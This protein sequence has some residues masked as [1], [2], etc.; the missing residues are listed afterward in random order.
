MTQLRGEP[1][2]LGLAGALAKK[3]VE[4]SHAHAGE[5]ALPAH[6]AV[7]LAQENEQLV[8]DA[9]VGREA[10]V[11]AF[12]GK[13]A[14]RDAV[15]EHA[16]FAQAGAGGDQRAIADLAR[17]GLR[18]ERE[19]FVR[20]QRI[21]AIGIGLE[22]VEQADLLEIQFGLQRG[23]I[24]DPGQVGHLHH[25]VL[26]RSGHAEAGMPDV[27]EIVAEKVADDFR[28]RGVVLARVGRGFF[29]DEPVVVFVGV[30]CQVGFGAADIACEKSA[31]GLKGKSGHVRVKGLGSGP[32]DKS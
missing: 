4:I 10:G 6:V 12:A 26:D 20:K 16:R 24:D 30:D 27:G 22:I 3:A 28:E 1:F 17:I 19:Q 32:S 7:L 15:P 13:G 25:A 11:A 5:D 8:A 2:G 14:M 29:R 21:D 23:G 18:V 9:V 31:S